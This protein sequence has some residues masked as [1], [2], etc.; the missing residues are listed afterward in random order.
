MKERVVERGMLDFG[1]NAVPE[2]ARGEGGR[3]GFVKPE[4]LVGQACEAQGRGQAEEGEQKEAA[5]WQGRAHS[6][7]GYAKNGEERTGEE[8]GKFVVDGRG[9]AVV[10]SGRLRER[11]ERICPDT[12]EFLAQRWRCWWRWF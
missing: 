8:E 9:G 3:S 7:K 5:A 10:E 2:R 6:G 1:E 12:R 4:R 11:K